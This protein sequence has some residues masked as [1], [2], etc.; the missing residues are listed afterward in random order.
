MISNRK[1]ASISSFVRSLY[2]YVGLRERERERASLA[3]DA[4][5]NV[6]KLNRSTRFDY[7]SI[8]SSDGQFH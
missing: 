7:H 8:D 5:A 3:V 2:V 6:V 1:C 4:I